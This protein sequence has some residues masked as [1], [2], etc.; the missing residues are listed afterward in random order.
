MSPKRKTGNL[1]T[2]FE[3]LTI[4]TAFNSSRQNPCS[5]MMEDVP[6]LKEL[7]QRGTQSLRIT[8]KVKRGFG[9]FGG[10]GEFG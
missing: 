3:F 6:A 1:I 9:G 7:I 10:T 8:G 5:G 4:Y 2:N